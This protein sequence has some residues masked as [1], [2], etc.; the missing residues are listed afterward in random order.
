MDEPNKE[1]PYSTSEDLNASRVSDLIACDMYRDGVGTIDRSLITPTTALFIASQVIGRRIEEEYLNTRAEGVLPEFTHG[2]D[3]ITAMQVET[4][5]LHNIL[6]T[7]KNGDFK[8]LKDFINDEGSIC[9]AVGLDETDDEMSEDEQRRWLN[10]GD[11][12]YL[13]SDSI[14]D[15]GDGTKMVLPIPLAIEYPEPIAEVIKK[16]AE[17]GEVN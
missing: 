15:E 5:K 14:P 4:G 1:I 2:V 16:L 6:L 17:G 9:Y 7:A 12:L 11:R 13:T 10:A 3:R 8:G